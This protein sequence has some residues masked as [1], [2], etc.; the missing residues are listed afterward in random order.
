MKLK[1]FKMYR[2]MYQ[3]MIFTIISSRIVASFLNY[4][5]MLLCISYTIR[6]WSK[7]KFHAFREIVKLPKR[8]LRNTEEG[9]DILLCIYGTSRS[10]K[11]ERRKVSL[12]H[13][14]IHLVGSGSSV[15]KRARVVCVFVVE[16]RFSRDCRDVCTQ[17][18]FKG[19]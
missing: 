8:P 2:R 12:T 1:S 10:G 15:R 9:T 5:C 18:K 6:H 7:Y 16:A 19:K 17:E 13:S 11:I 3:T 4:C 14:Q